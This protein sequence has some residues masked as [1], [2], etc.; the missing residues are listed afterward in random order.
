MDMRLRH[1]KLWICC[2]RL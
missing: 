1:T 2:S